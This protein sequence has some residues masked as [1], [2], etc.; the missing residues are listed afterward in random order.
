MGSYRL[1]LY[2][3]P[4]T[5]DSLLLSVL[6]QIQL[7]KNDKTDLADQVPQLRLQVCDLL[8]QRGEIGD[9]EHSV[10]FLSESC[11]GGFPEISVLS[12]WLMAT[13]EVYFEDGN[14]RTYPSLHPNRPVLQIY[15][16][17]INSQPYYDSI[18]EKI[19]ISTPEPESPQVHPRIKSLC[20]GTWNVLGATSIEK[21]LLI[22]ELIHQHQIDILCLQESHLYAQSLETS[23]YKWLLGPQPTTRASRGCGFMIRKQLD[24][25]YKFRVHT[26]NICHLELTFINEAQKLYIICVHKYSEGDIRSTLETSQLTS[27]IRSLML[28]GEV[29]LCG[30]LNSH[31]G[32]D[33]HGH[34]N[35]VGPVLCH[36]K[37]NNNGQELFALCEELNL[38]ILTTIFHSSTE[39]T[40]YRSGSKS[41][42]DHVITPGNAHYHIT[43]LHGHWTKYSDHKL[44]VLSLHMPSPRT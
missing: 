42:L 19:L 37:T 22:D 24:L 30:D 3:I 39:C 23:R 43:K 10:N 40:W 11:V 21:R 38:R 13:I 5:G 41:Q 4:R 14:R 35:I 29:I 6:H 8:R 33:I 32:K 26:N 12:K 9:A 2:D 34:Q 44:L 28:Q 20:L 25:A 31:F 36:K 15:Q 7:F 17:Q 1:Q 27:I 18:T 16:Y